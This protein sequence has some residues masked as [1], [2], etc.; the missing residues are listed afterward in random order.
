MY[1]TCIVKNQQCISR[2]VVREVP[3]TVLFNEP[4]IPNQQVGTIAFSQW[5]PGNFFFRQVIAEVTNPY[6]INT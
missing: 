4:A 5:V 2:E 6:V 3:E 1:D